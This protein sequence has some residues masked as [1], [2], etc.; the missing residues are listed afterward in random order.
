MTVVESPSTCNS[1]PRDG[2]A[3]NL[4][5]GAIFMPRGQANPAKLLLQ[6]GI[7]CGDHDTGIRGKWMVCDHASRRGFAGG[8]TAFREECGEDA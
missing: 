5:G 2:R 7:S 4:I 8:R 3:R 6:S 1:P